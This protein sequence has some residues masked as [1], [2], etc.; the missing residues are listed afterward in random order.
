ESAA[1]YATDAIDPVVT[2]NLSKAENYAR[3]SC[4]GIANLIV[5]NCLDGTLATAISKKVQREHHQIPMRPMI[6]EGLKPTNE[7]TRIEAFVYQ[8]KSYYERYV[9]SG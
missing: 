2:V 6:Y 4:S 9:N 5:L 3:S 8:V 7:K 1:P